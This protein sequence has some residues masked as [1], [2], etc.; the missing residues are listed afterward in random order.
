MQ[1][2]TI[3]IG[4]TAHMVVVTAQRTENDVNG[5]PQALIQVWT[6]V[7]GG[8]VWYPKM[9]GYRD[10]NDMSYKVQVWQGLDMAITEFMLRFELTLNNRL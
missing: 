9:K 6:T 2:H 1:Q 10:R 7:N 4:D 8:H 5:N 3:L